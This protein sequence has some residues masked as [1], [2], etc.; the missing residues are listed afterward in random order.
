MQD[1]NTASPG[2][3]PGKGSD[4][5]SDIAAGVAAQRAQNLNP[6]PPASED[7]ARLAAAIDRLIT[8]KRMEMLVRMPSDLGYAMT[9]WDGWLLSEEEKQVLSEQ[10]AEVMKE[11]VNIDPRYLLAIGFGLSVLSIYGTRI[12]GYY[13]YKQEKKHNAAET[14]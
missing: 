11:F 14:K 10:T 4:P 13:Q 5:V 12:A 1:Q 3:V 6:S 7:R 9:G 8:P 2:A